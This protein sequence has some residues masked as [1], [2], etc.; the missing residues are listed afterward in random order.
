MTYRDLMVWQKSMALANAIYDCTKLFPK[1]ETYGLTSQMRRAAVSIPSN[2]AEGKARGNKETDH[3]LRI[4]KG[5]LYELETQSMLA[6]D[7]QF[8]SEDNLKK[9]LSPASSLKPQAF[10]RSEAERS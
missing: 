4:A 5:S 1:E 9:S 2:I 10:E 3:F 6:K 7:Q 8:I